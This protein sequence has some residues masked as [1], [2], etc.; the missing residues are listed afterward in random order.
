MVKVSVLPHI[1]M[2]PYR[3]Q[4]TQTGFNNPKRKI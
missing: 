3:M 4:L 2:M 1:S